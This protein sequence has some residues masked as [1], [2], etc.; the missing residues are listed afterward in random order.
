M[1]RARQMVGIFVGL[2]LTMGA[3]KTTLAAHPKGA[4]PKSAPAPTPAAAPTPARAPTPTPAPEPGS[5]I[6][7]TV[8]QVAGKEAYLQPGA[9]GGLRRGARVSLNNKEYVV[10][11]TSDSFAVVDA[12]K[13]PPHELDKGR[14]QV[15][16]KTENVAR[17]LPQPQPLASFEHAWSETEPPADSQTPKFVPLSES[18]EN[19]RYDVR[20]S[21]MTGGMLPL[22]QPTAGIVAAEIGARIHAEPFAAPATLDLDMS[23]QRWFA[24][25][26]DSRN[27]SSARSL[28][29]VRELLVGY[30]AGTVSASVGRMRYAASTLGTLDGARVGASIGEGLALGAFGGLLP[31]PLGGEPSLDAQRFGVEGRYS[32]PDLTLRPEGALVLHG[33]TFRGGLDER[34]LSGVFGIY[35]ALSRIGGHVEVSNFDTNNPWKAAPV[36]LTAAGVDASMRLGV[37]QLGGR[38]DLRQ[39][40]RSRWLASFLP[41]SWLCRTVPS[42]PLVTSNSEPCDGSVSTRTLG[43]VDAGLEIDNVSMLVGGTAIGDLTQSG[44]PTMLGGLATARVVRIEQLLR[45]EGSVSY[46]HGTDIDMFSGTIGPG[47]TLLHDNLDLSAYYRNATLQYRATST[48]YAQHGFGGV[49]MLFPNSDLL[50]TVQGESIAGSDV[51]AILFY[52]TMMWR[53]RP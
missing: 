30:N 5:S 53:P 20:L 16:A 19:R 46:S 26:L 34:R 39:P 2:Y 21:M 45:V 1:T 32:R 8:V 23:L 4:K 7:V 33:S 35:P 25:N 47:F 27:G 13:D 43:E 38:F 49:A 22:N 36:E 15:T 10:V 41:A 18:E 24:A 42:P 31:D 9:M 44:E 50:L 3:A 51:Q 37:F 48:S 14:A 52:A 12:G 40:E 29:W 11:Q 28:L 6:E 17:Q